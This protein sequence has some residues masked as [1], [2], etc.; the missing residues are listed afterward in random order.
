MEVLQKVDANDFFKVVGI[1]S[2]LALGNVL[3]YK[4]IK[5]LTKDKE[6]EAEK[7]QVNTNT[8]CFL[9]KADAVVYTAT[10]WGAGIGVATAVYKAFDSAK[11]EVVDWEY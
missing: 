2:S 10:V 9:E 3:L 7:E 4:G 1:F 6:D 8:N 5:K 11:N